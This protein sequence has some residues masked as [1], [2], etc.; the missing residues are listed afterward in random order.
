MYLYMCAYTYTYLTAQS[1]VKTENLISK[2]S[3]THATIKRSMLLKCRVHTVLLAHLRCKHIQNR[4]P[5]QVEPR[6]FRNGQCC[7]SI[8]CAQ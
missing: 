8:A 4:S 5:K 2:V 6:Q 1:G 3:G 7:S